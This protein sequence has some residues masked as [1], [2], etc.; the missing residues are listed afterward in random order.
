MLL[1]DLAAADHADADL[2]AVMGVL[3]SLMLVLSL[4]RL[5]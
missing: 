2:A 5:M 4:L 3:L 1:G